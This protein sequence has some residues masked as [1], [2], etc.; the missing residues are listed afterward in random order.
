[1]LS[2]SL[3][4]VDS[5]LLQVHDLAHLLH[6][7]V[8]SKSFQHTATHCLRVRRRCLHLSFQL[9]YVRCGRCLLLMFIA[10]GTS[11]SFSRP[12]NLLVT[13]ST[14]STSSDYSPATCPWQIAPHEVIR[15]LRTHRTPAAALFFGV[16]CSRCQVSTCL[17]PSGTG[18]QSF[19]QLLLRET[20]PILRQHGLCLLE[21]KCE[22]Q[23]STLDPLH[24]RLPSYRV[25][26]QADA[27][28]EPADTFGT[29]EDD[30]DGAQQG[31]TPLAPYR[32]FHPLLL[33]LHGSFWALYHPDFAGIN[34]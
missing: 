31:H 22:T 1:M 21:A 6:H 27:L 10:S 25:L 18:L 3:A 11:F 14:T 20:A 19:G 2:W 29:V 34:L 16:S 28:S 15:R 7:L 33:L 9:M 23:W 26:F 8:H 4:H 13:K 17:A 30:D 12:H 24:P 32:I 5:L